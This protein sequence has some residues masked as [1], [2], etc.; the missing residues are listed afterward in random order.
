MSIS[1]RRNS[2]R[3]SSISIDS[4]RKT[5]SS[6][7]RG[8]SSARE[9]SN[10][11]VK[12]TRKSNLFKSRLIKQDNEYFIKRRENIRRKDREDELEAS[13][14]TGATKRQGS[15]ITQSTRGLLGRMLDFFGVLLIGWAVQNLPNIIEK[16]QGLIEIIKKVVGV[17]SKFFDGLTF[18]FTGLATGITTL[19]D[20]FRKFNFLGQKKEIETGSDRANEGITK[21]D[22]DFRESIAELQ[23]DENI[24]NANKRADE[25]EEQQRSEQSGDSEVDITSSLNIRG[26][27][28]QENDNQ[29]IQPQTN[30]IESTNPQRSSEAIQP[31][32]NIGNL[33]AGFFTPIT[34]EDLERER[35]LDAEEEAQETFDEEQNE[36]EGVLQDTEKVAKTFEPSGGQTKD[37]SGVKPITESDVDSTIKKSEQRQKKSAE[38]E[39]KKEKINLKEKEKQIEVTAVKKRNVN[40]KRTRRNKNVVMIIEKPSSQTPTVVSG[41]KLSPLSLPKSSSKNDS[42]LELQSTTSLKYT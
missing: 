42:L 25:L 16:I 27:E 32:T 9:Q 40:I 28:T 39:S 38:V 31:K 34:E 22:A 35:A 37:A 41:S 23:N 2:L 18:F 8:I 5:T 19:L 36:V 17:L 10:A 13:S 15:I 6:F 7:S 1:I 21:L 24:K 3:K 12:Q 26:A 33:E 14:I 11:I 29:I 30:N 4:I 20:T